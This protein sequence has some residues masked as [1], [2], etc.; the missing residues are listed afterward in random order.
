MPSKFVIR[1]KTT[2]TFCISS[3]HRFFME[4]LDDSVLFTSRSRAEHAV[5]EMDKFLTKE[6]NPYGGNTWSVTI[7]NQTTVYHTFLQQYA[8][9]LEESDPRAHADTISWLRR[10]G[11]E[12]KPE[13]EVLE[14]KL[15]I[16]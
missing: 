14:V 2:N 7:G 12:R 3:K 15:T 16:V 1:E 13:F 11:I 8:N 5:K 4:D 9:L 10:D 6:V